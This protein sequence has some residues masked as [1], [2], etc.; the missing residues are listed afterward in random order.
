MVRDHHGDQYIDLMANIQRFRCPSCASTSGIE[1]PEIEQG[2]KITKAAAGKIIDAALHSDIQTCSEMSGVDK[3][4]ISRL[5]SSKAETLLLSQPTFKTCR[6]KV[7]RPSL[8]ALLN[9]ST[10]EAVGFLP[11][12]KMHYVP[13]ILE[14]LGVETVIPCPEIAP[15]TLSWRSSMAITLTANDFA[16]MVS[17]LLKRAAQKM[18]GALKL[19][20]SVTASSAVN[21]LSSDL[22]KLSVSENIAL[23]KLAPAGTPARGFIRM[24]DRILAVHNAPD[25]TTA[26]S[27]LA[28]WQEDCRDTWRTIFSGVLN[29]IETYKDLILTN[30]YSLQP[31][32][33]YPL[34]AAFRPANIM[35]IQLHRSRL[36]SENTFTLRR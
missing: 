16:T 35:T 18:L 27:L 31:A 20:D 3:S 2:F 17:T 32:A 28:K 34:H 5:L 29:F 14:R 9:Q 7:L 12:G 19:P 10:Q 8:L 23:S 22:S 15:H 30:P 25:L 36:T 26:R 1:T 33:S 13:N 6:L 11:G 24:R 21:L 4:T